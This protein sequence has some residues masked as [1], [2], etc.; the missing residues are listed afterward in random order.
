MWKIL[1]LTP[2]LFLKL[3]ACELKGTIIFIPQ[4]RVGEEILKTLSPVI[5]QKEQSYR[6]ASEPNPVTRENVWSFY[7]KKQDSVS[8]YNA[9]LRTIG[10]LLT[11]CEGSFQR[12][13]SQSDT[14]KKIIQ[15]VAPLNLKIYIYSR[16]NRLLA[17]VSNLNEVFK[18]FD[19]DTELKES[20]ADEVTRVQFRVEINNDITRAQIIFEDAQR[21]FG[22]YSLQI[23]AAPQTLFEVNELAALIGSSLVDDLPIHLKASALNLW[24][25]NWT[26]ILGSLSIS[27]LI[28]RGRFLYLLLLIP[29]GF[30]FLSRF[31]DKRRGNFKEKTSE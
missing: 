30:Y 11:N 15:K 27:S 1:A 29:F 17:T 24:I 14:Q 5:I 20:S 21:G 22:N 12:L 10:P 2:L 3:W 18:N 28:K 16:D 19:F 31:V 6:I 25:S 26:S 23:P 7:P 4:D 9:V 8:H 13:L